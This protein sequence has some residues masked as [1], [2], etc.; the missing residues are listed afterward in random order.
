MC[1]RTSF[2]TLFLVAE[3]VKSFG[4]R[5]VPKVLTTPATGFETASSPEQAPRL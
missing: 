3:L 2:K 4:F 1:C 5:R